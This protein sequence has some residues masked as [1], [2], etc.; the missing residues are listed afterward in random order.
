MMVLKEF[1]CRDCGH[2]FEEFSKADQNP[3]CPACGS[4]QVDV[5]LSGKVYGGLG[6]CSECSGNCSCC[7]GCHP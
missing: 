7:S 1:I 6:K 5:H 2:V 3:P 4:A